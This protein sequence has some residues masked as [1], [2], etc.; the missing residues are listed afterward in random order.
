M[1]L[2]KIQ[3]I[4]YNN[5]NKSQKFIICEL[6]NIN[7]DSIIYDY[8]SMYDPPD[9]KLKKVKELYY[10][11]S[12]Y[13]SH[14]LNNYTD[15]FKV[16]TKNWVLYKPISIN[17]DLYLNFILNTYFKDDQPK[18]KLFINLTYT[19]DFIG[20]IEKTVEKSVN[21]INNFF[22]N[23]NANNNAIDKIIYSPR[24]KI[25]GD[26]KLLKSDEDFFNPIFDTYIRGKQDTTNSFFL[27]DISVKNKQDFIYFT[28][29]LEYFLV[30]SL[31]Y[32]TEQI[33]YIYFF[34]Q[35]Y[36][37]LINQS[38]NGSFIIRLNHIIDTHLGRSL[39]RFIK[40]YYKNIYLVRDLDFSADIL[41]IVGKNFEGINKSDVKILKKL[42]K[43]IFFNKRESTDKFVFT[44]GEH[45]NVF[46]NKL[47]IKKNVVRQFVNFVKNIYLCKLI[48]FKNKD[49]Y[50][51]KIINKFNN[52][53]CN[54]IF[55]NYP[56]KYYVPPNIL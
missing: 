1:E 47:R 30:K 6:N 31:S 54:Y 20:Y 49:L 9:Y 16:S 3:E 48:K 19:C 46:N 7:K 8:E 51:D 36:Y 32:Y 26:T 15:R 23:N 42:F 53:I 22:K 39:L 13:D 35:I 21:Y 11:K 33:H 28:G 44:M 37:I 27:K 52:N 24:Y 43:N 40:K 34:F 4:N 10:Q 41:Y 18:Y 56:K 45:L 14:S 2:Y 50:F 5:I 55:K 12:K 17:N 29:G 38:K 25:A